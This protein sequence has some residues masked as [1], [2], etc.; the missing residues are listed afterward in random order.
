MSL[1]IV[2]QCVENLD[3]GF[4]VVILKSTLINFDERTLME[5]MPQ[6]KGNT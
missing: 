6:E 1:S 5:R 3:N 2:F 4:K